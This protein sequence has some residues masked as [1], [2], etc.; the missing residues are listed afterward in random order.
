MKVS[1]A[2]LEVLEGQRET[3]KAFSSPLEEEHEQE[4]D[5]GLLPWMA[6]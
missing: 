6:A 1:T 3:W 5:Q 2:R 4:Q